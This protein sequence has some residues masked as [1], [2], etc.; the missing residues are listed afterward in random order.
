[1]LTVYSE[2]QNE[3]EEDNRV[4]QELIAE[5]GNISVDISVFRH[6]YSLCMYDMQSLLEM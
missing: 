4:S 6:S 2:L 1:M 3:R 5:R